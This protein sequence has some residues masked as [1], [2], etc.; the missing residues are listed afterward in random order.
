MKGLKMLTP[1]LLFSLLILPVIAQAQD[2][3]ELNRKFYLSLGTLPLEITDVKNFD[4]SD[5]EIFGLGSAEGRVRVNLEDEAVSG[6]QFGALFGFDHPF[7]SWISGMFE[8]QLTVASSNSW[9][10]GFY[11]GTNIRFLRR[12]RFNVGVIPKLGYV[13]GKIDLGKAESLPGKSSIVALPEGTFSRGDEIKAEF[14]GFSF[15]LATV[16]EYILT[17]N[18]EVNC[19]LGY[20][21]GFISNFLIKAGDTEIEFDSAA[22]VRP[23]GSSNHVDIDPK[24]EQNGLFFMVGMNFVF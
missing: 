21:K 12:E 10:Y 17:R 19:Q 5:W 11:G 2:D 15:Q 6:Q 3:A 20:T 9:V 13:Q 7:R 22:I 18:L 23:D 4:I 14:S 24:A 16:A 8:L 1:V